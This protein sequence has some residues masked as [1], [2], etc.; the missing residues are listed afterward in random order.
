VSAP[1]EPGRTP[2]AGN[3]DDSAD[4]AGITQPLPRDT[5]GGRYAGGPGYDRPGYDRGPGYDRPGYGGSGYDRPGYGGPGYGG[6]GGYQGGYVQGRQHDGPGFA[7]RAQHAGA[8]IARHVK[9]PETKEFFKTSEFAVWLV[10]VIGILIAANTV[11]GGNEDH[12]RADEAWLYVALTS[13][14]YVISRGISKSGTRR[15]YGD[16]PMDRDDR[17]Y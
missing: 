11:G 13:A 15:G 2:A 5:E 9:T 8:A 4:D 10:T 14:A 7:D 1:L 6:E 12:F 16:A 3:T 17:G